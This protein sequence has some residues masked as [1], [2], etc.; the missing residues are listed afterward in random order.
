MVEARPTAAQPTKVSRKDNITVGVRV[1]PPLPRELA[2]KKFTDC[3]A[4]DDENSRVF[5]SL[6]D[7][8][9]V[10]S[11]QSNNVPDG[12]AAYNFDHCF[13]PASTQ[14]GVF[15][16]TVRPAVDAVLDGFNA[17]VF[18]YGQTGTGK[19]YSMQGT[20]ENPGITPRAV[21]HL[22][23]GLQRKIHG[24]AAGD[25]SFEEDESEEEEV[26]ASAEDEE[27]EEVKDEEIDEGDEGEEAVL[28][29]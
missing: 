21:T 18:A 16:A 10:I 19:T 23:E 14:E 24:R 26:K 9:V 17:T 3:V 29:R 4:V 20:N 8:P 1:R 11:K 2:N 13:G 27:E 25:D 28:M 12:V 6:Q 22:F 7:E 5:V 15:T